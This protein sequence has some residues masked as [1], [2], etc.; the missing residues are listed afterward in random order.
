V[1]VG[2]I[3]GDFDPTNPE[4]APN[5]VAY[6]S[7]AFGEGVTWEA[8]TA[9]TENHGTAVAEVVLDVA[10]D[11]QLSFAQARDIVSWHAAMTWLLEDQ[12]VDVVTSSIGTHRGPMD[13]SSP[14][15]EATTDAWAA[16]VPVIVAA[17]NEAET[18]WEGQF[19][20]TDGDGLHEFEPGVEVATAWNGQSLPAGVPLTVDLL[21]DDWPTS[22]DAYR[23]VLFEQ[24]RNGVWQPV[25]AAERPAELTVP[26]VPLRVVTPQQTNAIGFGVARGTEAGDNSIELFTLG[27][28]ID[29]AVAAGSITAPGS[30]RS[31]V[32]V[33]AYNHATEFL[34]GY[35]SQGPTN[36]GRR[37]I[38]VIG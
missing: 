31:V 7:F 19:R 16:G 17:G 25:F 9:T 3:D 10:P 36:D 18:H 6:R 1:K 8:P 21:W 22:S 15:E 34:E 29:P 30:S 27:T 12:G 33:G 32:A 13:G 2:V 4:V 20:D 5:L 23:L 14:M 24:D 26:F 28:P 35:S 11:V 38:D 37:G